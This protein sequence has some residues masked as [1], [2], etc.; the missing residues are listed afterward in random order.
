MR[1]FINSTQAKIHAVQQKDASHIYDFKFSTGPTGEKKQKETG[2]I[3]FFNIFYSS[4]YIK[5]I[6]ST[7]NQFLKSIS[8]MVFG[9]KPL[10]PSACFTLT[11]LNSIQT[12]WCQALH[13][14]MWSVA[15]VL[16]GPALDLHYSKCGTQTAGDRNAASQAPV[17]TSQAGVRFYPI[18]AR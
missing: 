6:I 15:T 5:D 1:Q 18:F 3:K 13:G 12:H 10:K 4:Q 7:Y 2:E 14:H 9:A 8:E 16:G 11:K 17:H